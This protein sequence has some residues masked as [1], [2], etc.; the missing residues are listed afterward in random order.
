M[1]KSSKKACKGTKIVTKCNKNDPVVKN[2]S[3]KIEKQDAIAAKVAK[4]KVG[5]D[6]KTVLSP[7]PIEPTYRQLLTA[8]SGLLNVTLYEALPNEECYKL[9]EK[10]CEKY[11]VETP[12]RPMSLP[13]IVF[14]VNKAIEVY[15]G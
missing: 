2:E 15:N 10:A 6:R 5:S 14:C 4:P 9:I 12:E 11:G 7:L 13:V 3:P 1:K 8:L